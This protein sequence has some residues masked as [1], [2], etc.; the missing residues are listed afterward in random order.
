MVTMKYL[1]KRAKG[2]Q[3]NDKTKQKKI[4]KTDET[5]IGLSVNEDGLDEL[6]LQ[7]FKVTTEL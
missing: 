5:K 2:K 3:N 1:G 6:P 4:L 7:N